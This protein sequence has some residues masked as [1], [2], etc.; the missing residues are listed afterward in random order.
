MTVAD[1]I[2]IRREELGLSQ[3]ELAS[4]CGYAYR[5]A[6][7][8]MENAGDNI[9]TKRIAKVANALNTS[10]AYLMG[11]EDNATPENAELLADLITDGEMLSYIRK[12]HHM[13]DAQRG[14]V[15][16]YIDMLLEKS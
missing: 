8:K 1:R 11:W 3:D 13:T 4:R 16:G 5:S 10:I 9:G 6:I 15:Y 7:C 12:L 2:R 14:R